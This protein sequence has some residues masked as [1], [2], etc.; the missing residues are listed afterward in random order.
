MGVSFYLSFLLL[1]GA[2]LACIASPVYACMES[3]CACFA[4]LCA[5]RTQ[6]FQGF[7]LALVGGIVFLALA[8]FLF[9]PMVL[10]VPSKFA[11]SFTLG[12]LLFIVA[13]AMLRGP[14]TIA[15]QLVSPSKAAFSITY[16]VS[17]GAWPP[18]VCRRSQ[19]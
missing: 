7:V 17:I 10:F 16:V 1:S 18:V 6:R 11:V 5:C 4:A 9:L 19:P 8:I 15:R 12:S 14:R 13:F 3:W 2:S